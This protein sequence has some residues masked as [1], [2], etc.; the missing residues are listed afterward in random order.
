[1]KIFENAL[2]SFIRTDENNSNTLSVDSMIFE[3]G[4][5]ISVFKD[6]RIRVEGAL[7]YQN[8]VQLCTCIARFGILQGYDVQLPHFA[9]NKRLQL[10]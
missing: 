8:N 10:P 7:D 1:M 4:G 3:N 2:F 9:L 5:K 6:I